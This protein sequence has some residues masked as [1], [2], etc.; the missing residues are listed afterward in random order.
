MVVRR[1][2]DVQLVQTGRFESRTRARGAILAG[3]VY[4]DGM[5]VDKPGYQVTEEALIEI[6]VDP[7]PYVSRGGL[8]LEAALDAFGVN[9]YGKVALDAGA[10]TGGFTHCLLQ[11]GACRVYAVDVGYGQLDWTLRQD[12]RVVVFERTNLRYL[13]PDDLDPLPSLTTLDLSFIS[14]AKVLPAVAGFL[15]PGG[16]VV[17]LVKPQF[18]AGAKA[19]GR[20][21]I[22]RSAETHRQVL[23]NVSAAAA[24]LGFIV[25]DF[26]PSPLRGGDGNREFFIW[27]KLPAVTANTPNPPPGTETGGA[28]AG[29]SLVMS[30]ATEAEIIARVVD[31]AWQTDHREEDG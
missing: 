23:A 17:A 3:Q 22:V 12:S 18:E 15:A 20:G 5:K 14:L 24:G 25:G 8:K 31:Q 9:P 6:R 11:R 7:N 21:G 30:P 16:E 29:T 2:L 27:L 10:S 19:V 28:A 4:V 1:R 13:G 26:A